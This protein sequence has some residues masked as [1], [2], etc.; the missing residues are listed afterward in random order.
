MHQLDLY[1]VKEIPITGIGR[2]CRGR[3]RCR[4]RIARTDE[5]EQKRCLFL[6]WFA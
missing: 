2:S 3:T 6:H 4:A 1:L 5:G